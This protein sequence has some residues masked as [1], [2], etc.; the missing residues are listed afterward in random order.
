MPIKKVASSK[1]TSGIQKKPSCAGNSSASGIQKKPSRAGKGRAVKPPEESKAKPQEPINQKA[2]RKGEVQ[3]K[4][5]EVSQLRS[6]LIAAPWRKPQPLPPPPARWRPPSPRSEVRE[7]GCRADTTTSLSW[8]WINGKLCKILQ[9]T[10]T[11]TPLCCGSG[12]TMAPA[13]PVASLCCASPPAS[14]A[15]P[16]S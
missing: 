6:L 16:A 2:N 15:S 13:S 5:T 11:V 12:Q 4:P 8:Q 10:T 3:D 1:V 14:P 9:T 7:D